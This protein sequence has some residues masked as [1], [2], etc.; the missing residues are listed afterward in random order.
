MREDGLELTEV[1]SGIGSEAH[2]LSRILFSATAFEPKPMSGPQFRPTWVRFRGRI[3]DIDRRLSGNPQTNTR[4]SG[5]AD[6]LRTRAAVP[7]H[8][9]DGTAGAASIRSRLPTRSRRPLGGGRH[10]PIMFTTDLALKFDPTYRGISKRFL[11]NADEFE[12][13]GAA[14]AD[15]AGAGGPRGKP[16]ACPLPMAPLQSP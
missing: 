12:V 6:R 2:I 7:S 16:R 14:G 1:A 5:T 11:N 8:A 15:G 13:A 10:A 4:S 3:R 9:R